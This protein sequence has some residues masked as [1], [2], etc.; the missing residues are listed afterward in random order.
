M[1]SGSATST[2]GLIIKGLIIKG[3]L[4]AAEDITAGFT[5]EGSIDLQGHRLIVAENA[6]V[7][8]TVTAASV[9]V[10][11][12]L[13]GH[14]AADRLEIASTGNV[15]ASVVAP[16]LLLH[17]GAQLSGPVNTERAQAAGKVARHRQK[18]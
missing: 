14:V 7:Q 18:T 17:D 6:V 10:H 5:L 1:H 4:S 13:S 9:V 11:G 15:E 16:H 12:R 3:D 2:S 8:A